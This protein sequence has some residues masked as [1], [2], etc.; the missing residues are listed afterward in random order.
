[1]VDQSDSSNKYKG[2]TNSSGVATMTFDGGEFEWSQDSDADFS[3][4][5]V[6]QEDE[7]YLVP[8][9]GVTTDQLKTYFPNGVIVSPLTIVQ[10]KDN[11]GIT[12]SLTRIYNSNK[13]DDWEGSWDKTKKN[14]TL[15]S[16]IKTSTASTETYVL[17]NVDA[18]LIGFSNGL[19]QIGTEK[20]VDYHKA[21][22][23][24]FKVSGVPSNLKIVITY[25]SQNAPLTVEMENDVIQRFQLSDLLLNTE[26]IGNSTIWSVH[27]QS[28]DGG[29]LSADDLKD[30]NITFS[31]YGK[32]V[33]SSDIPA[34]KVLYGNYD[35]TVTPPSPLEAQSGT[36]NVNAPAVNKE[37]LIVNNTNVTFKVTAKQPLL[38]RPQI[39]DFVYGDKTWSTELDGTKTCVGVITDVRSKDFDFIGLE[40]LT[41]GFGQIH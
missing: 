15:T 14:L 28:F 12:E 21:L 29:T 25:G 32:K 37:I 34:G 20:T 23:F 2:T 22:D 41:A 6:F 39:G 7:K 17:F 30:L 31:F 26:T 11:S 24:G 33:I 38:T 19:F 40:N 36:L 3:S 1:M 27:V 9:D 4:C 13:I 35:Y 8:A 16:V 18:G 5:P 10:D